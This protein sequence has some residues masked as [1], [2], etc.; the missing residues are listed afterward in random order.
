MSAALRIPEAVVQEALVR[1]LVGLGFAPPRAAQ[2][3]RLFTQASM[4]GV[5]SHGLSR[6]P[7][8][9]GQIRR[10]RVR[11][12]AEPTRVAGFGAWEQWDGQLG[13]GNLNAWQATEQAMALARAHGIGAVA[14]RNT[15][16][17]MRAGTYGWQAA[18][19]GFG[20]VA[21]TNTEPNMPAWG[22]R[23]KTLGNNPLV[24]AVPR[25]G[26]PVVLDFAMSQFSYG[27]LELAAR[28]G[29]RLPLPGGYDEAGELTT[30][31]AAILRSGRLLPIGYW[32]GAGLALAL[33]LL[34]AALSGGRTTRAL[35]GLEEEYGVSQIFLALDVGTG[36]AREDLDRLAAETVEALHRAERVRPDTPIR[37]PGERVLETRAESRRLGVPV[38]AGVWDEILHL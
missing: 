16:H 28:R 31:P 10:G 32:K 9:V 38:D 15:N 20:L 26:A 4:D 37:Y 30:D 35:G 17:W 5:A 36:Q 21:W 29:E 34:A 18:E 8:F 2:C 19:A 12:D 33:D 25:G 13:P 11:V 1:V 3:A 14:L 22:G 7:R 24:I 27:R 6:F 23:G